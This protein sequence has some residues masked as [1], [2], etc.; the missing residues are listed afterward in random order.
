MSKNRLYYCYKENLM[1][2][3]IKIN[4]YRI[5]CRAYINSDTCTPHKA[6]TD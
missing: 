5:S 6:S 4:N 1:N 3:S 2:S